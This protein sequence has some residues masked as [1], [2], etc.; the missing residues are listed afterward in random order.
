MIEA[1]VL[2][3]QWLRADRSNDRVSL[4]DKTMSHILGVWG[5]VSDGVADG[6][7]VG[8]G[9]DCADASDD[10]S[11]S[12]SLKGLSVGAV[13]LML[14]CKDALSLLESVTGRLPRSANVMSLRGISLSNLA[15][16]SS[17]KGTLS[18]W[19]TSCSRLHINTSRLASPP[20]DLTSPG[21]NILANKPP[22]HDLAFTLVSEFVY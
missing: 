2:L 14:C 20:L 16:L 3:L 21:R 9:A 8:G 13:A 5:V 18:N 19:L 12:S 11:L 6:G 15:A 10:R 7:V 1:I 22:K 17:S 4:L